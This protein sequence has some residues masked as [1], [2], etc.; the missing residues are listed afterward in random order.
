MVDVGDQVG[1]SNRFGVNRMEISSRRFAENFHKLRR[2]WSIAAQLPNS[3]WLWRLRRN[4]IAALSFK[5]L[6]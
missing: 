4:T 6:N 1:H 3:A 2:G 5:V